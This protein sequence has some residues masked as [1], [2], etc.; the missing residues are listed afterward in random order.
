MREVNIKI[1]KIHT[2]FEDYGIKRLCVKICKKI[3]HKDERRYEKWIKKNKLS[4]KEIEMQKNKKF[5]KEPKFSILIPLY[6]TPEKY[7]HEIVESILKQS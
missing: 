7:L 1:E 4:T 6:K 2:L 5:I 3:T